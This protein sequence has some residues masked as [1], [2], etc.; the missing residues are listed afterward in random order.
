MGKKNQLS[1]TLSNVALKYRDLSLPDSQPKGS[2][3]GL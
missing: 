3:P 2:K 1:P